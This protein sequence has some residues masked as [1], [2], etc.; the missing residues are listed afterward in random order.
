MEDKIQR[1]RFELKY[2]ISEPKAQQIRQFVRSYLDCDLYGQTQPDLSYRV[3][4]LYMDSDNLKTYRDTI[5]GDRNRFK[6]RL[7][8]YDAESGPVYFE[9]KRRYNKVIRKERA[10][11]DRKHIADLL[12][13]N[14]P[15]YDHLIHKTPQQLHALANFSYLQNF[16]D[17]RPKIHV[18][19]LREAYERENSNTARVTFDRQVQS[20]TSFRVDNGI[21]ANAKNP[22]LVFG[23]TVIMELKFTDRFP[24]WM[25]ELIQVFH[26]R[27]QSAA[28]YV[29][30]V[31]KMKNRRL[32]AV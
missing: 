27:Q 15:T 29:D 32:T 23:N 8:Y 21:W 1:Q 26:L 2:R 5:N 20:S 31:E 4:S 3:N 17:A 28:K 19:Y 6:L 9:I 16:I 10:S 30:G 12:K 13:G 25:E 11:V 24:H 18:S 7:R 22:L 14:A